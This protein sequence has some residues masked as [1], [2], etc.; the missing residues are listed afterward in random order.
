M[1]A[2]LLRAAFIMFTI[3]TVLEK[4]ARSILLGIVFQDPTIPLLSVMLVVVRILLTLSSLAFY[5]GFLLPRWMH[6]ILTQF[7][8]EKS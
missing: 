8:K 1:K 6:A 5:G 3:A 4:V 7:S 2:K